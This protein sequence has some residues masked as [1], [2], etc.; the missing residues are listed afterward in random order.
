M[1]AGDARSSEFVRVAP[2][3][4]ETLH[5]RLALRVVFDLAIALPARR[6]SSVSIYR[7]K[8]A[9]RSESA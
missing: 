2:P 9:E 4:V 5:S 3:V 7:N 6:Y 8:V 1:G